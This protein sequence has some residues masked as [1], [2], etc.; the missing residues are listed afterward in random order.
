MKDKKLSKRKYRIRSK[1]Q[2]HS[3]KR[4]QKKN[5]RSLKRKSTNRRTR[6]RNTRRNI[7]G[8]RNPFLKRLRKNVN[9]IKKAEKADEL[10]KRQKRR[11]E[12][13]EEY[14]SNDSNDIPE[15]SESSN[16]SVL[17]G[18]SGFSGSSVVSDNQLPPSPTELRMREDYKLAHWERGGPRAPLIPS[19]TYET[20][21]WEG[22][23]YW[24][25]PETLSWV[26]TKGTYWSRRKGPLV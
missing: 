15:V 8:G 23:V 16:V 14:D 18:L 5:K 21:V 10:K 17:S 20:R 6:R 11:R 13:R 26:P 3:R 24:F 1:K 25:N 2:K 9:K 4:T 22:N 12:L 19:R 7:H